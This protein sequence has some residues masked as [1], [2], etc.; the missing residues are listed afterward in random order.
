[1]TSA[2]YTKIRIF[3]SYSKDTIKYLYNLFFSYISNHANNK[4]HVANVDDICEMFTS[5]ADYVVI[6]NRSAKYL[7]I[8]S[9]EIEKNSVGYE[10]R[11]DTPNSDEIF[12][13]YM[14]DIIDRIRDI[15]DISNY[16]N[17]G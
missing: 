6:F 2:D 5:S 3:N 10:Y 15:D 7:P 4:S 12:T 14:N 1:M 11:E 13:A 9:V 8:V 17:G 16:F